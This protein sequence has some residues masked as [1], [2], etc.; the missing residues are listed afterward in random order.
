[1]K[2]M[3]LNER[4]QMEFG[5]CFPRPGYEFVRDLPAELCLYKA[6]D[7][8]FLAQEDGFFYWDPDDTTLATPWQPRPGITRGQ[9][10]YWCK[11]A[12]E[13]LGLNKGQSTNWPIFEKVFGYPGGIDPL[14]GEKRKASHPLRFAYNNLDQSIYANELKKPIDAFFNNLNNE[15]DA[16]NNDTEQ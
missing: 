10:A 16:F 13:H 7:L 15:E 12:S 3:N 9:I 1:M 14:T 5:D 8:F 2:P 11:K 4:L 6:Q